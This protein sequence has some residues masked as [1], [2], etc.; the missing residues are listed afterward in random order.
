M[1]ASCGLRMDQIAV[2]LT[3]GLTGK[4]LCATI[5][6]NIEKDCAVAGSISVTKGAGKAVEIVAVGA[7]NGEKGRNIAGKGLTK[8]KISIKTNL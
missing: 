4:W 2:R 3:K 6:T 1:V 5:S 7:K 8:G